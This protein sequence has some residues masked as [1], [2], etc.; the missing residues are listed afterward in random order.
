MRALIKL[1]SCVALGAML[2]FTTSGVGFAGCTEDDPDGSKVAAARAAADAACAAEGNG[3]DTAPSHGKYVSCIAHQAKILSTGE[4]APLPTTCK[5]AVK[6]CAARSVCG[7]QDKGFATCCL[8]NSSG[9]VKCKT[10]KAENCT[11]AGGVVGTCASCCDAC[12]GGT[13]PSCPAP[14]PEPTP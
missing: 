13:G 7:K 1:A 10:R 6:K 5:G 9:E 14:S 8:T 2:V 12:D 11:E 3:C 4:N